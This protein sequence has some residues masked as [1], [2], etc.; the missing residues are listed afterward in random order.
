[1]RIIISYIDK[2]NKQKI[3]IDVSDEVATFI[4]TDNQRLRRQRNKINYYE[5]DIDSVD[6]DILESIADENTI[7][8]IE[9]QLIE[10]EDL[11]FIQVS[12][13]RTIKKLTL[14]RQYIIVEKWFKLKTLKEIAFTLH[15]KTPTISKV[16]KRT[17]AKMADLL[18]SDEEFA[19]SWWYKSKVYR[20][21]LRAEKA[22]I[23]REKR[24]EEARAQQER[25]NELKQQILKKI[26]QCKE[27][28]K[29]LPKVII[30]L[31]YSQYKFE[32]SKLLIKE[33]RE[34]GKIEN[35]ESLKDLASIY[36][37]V[38]LKPI[39]EQYEENPQYFTHK[40]NEIEEMLVNF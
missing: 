1:M 19:N 27:D 13:R 12:I 32:L 21:Y 39:L 28:L 35:L 8:T 40:F 17:L 11:N 22:R 38:E 6:E 7:E 4:N 16:H 23:E 37:E 31:F 15:K 9:D 25:H 30:T 18:K 26:Q 10:S 29:C 14:I 2:I 34:K 36:A 5:I 3:E 33:Q 20:D 24:E